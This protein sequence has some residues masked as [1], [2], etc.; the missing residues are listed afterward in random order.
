MKKVLDYYLKINDVTANKVASDSGKSNTTLSRAVNGDYENISTR[1]YLMLA[2]SLNKLPNRV[3]YEVEQLN[4][5]LENLKDDSNY[6]TILDCDSKGIWTNPA[7]HTELSNKEYNL[8]ILKES[9][10]DW[11]EN[12]D[13]YRDEDWKFYEVYNRFLENEDDFE[14]EE[15]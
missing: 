10:S 6:H 5:C 8:L 4:S 13:Q 14:L 9:F 7:T 2:K 15:E 11:L 1:I 12:I 3:F